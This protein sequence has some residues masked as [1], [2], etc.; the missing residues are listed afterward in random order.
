MGVWTI[1]ILIAAA[2][3]GFYVLAVLMARHHEELLGAAKAKLAQRA[4][5]DKVRAARQ[6]KVLADGSTSQAD[7]P[8]PAPDQPGS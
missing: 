4:R 2:W 3:L 7:T 1:A 8:T 5:E 6:A